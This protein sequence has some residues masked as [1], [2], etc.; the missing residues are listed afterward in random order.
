M[1]SSD[2]AIQPTEKRRTGPG[3]RSYKCS[4][5]IKYPSRVC[6]DALIQATLDSAWDRLSSIGAIDE[7]QDTKRFGFYAWAGDKR[8]SVWIAD[9]PSLIPPSDGT[10]P[11]IFLSREAVLAEPQLSATRTIWSFRDHTTS[12]RL[13]RR[14]KDCI[15]QSGGSIRIFQIQKVIPLPPDDITE[16]IFSMLCRGIL[17]LIRA[18]SNANHTVASA[19][20]DVHK[21]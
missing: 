16:T 18:S 21:G 9:S 1:N 14:I 2:T 6:R 5:P 13:E 12:L 11:T 4:H 10:S 20:H 3:F 19:I 15:K 7:Q 17:L 8:H